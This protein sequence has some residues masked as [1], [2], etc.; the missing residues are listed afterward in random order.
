MGQLKKALPIGLQS[1]SNIRKED[2]LYVDKTDLIY[3]LAQN[4]GY[5]FL[6]RPRRF[7]KSMLCS[8][9]EALFSGKNDLFNN[10]F[11]ENHWDWSVTHPVIRL[12]M[13]ATNYSNLQAVKNKLQ[14]VLKENAQL[15]QIQLEEGPDQASVF[16]SLIFQL[17]EK[18]QKQV[19]IIV[20]EYDKAIQDT[21][22]RE[23]QLAS[24]AMDELR[25]FYSAIKASDDYI[26]FCFMTGITKFTG[27]GL[28]SGANNF[29]DIS[30]D[31]A[32]SSI[33]G[34]TQGELEQGFGDYFE[35]YD[36]E[37]VKLWYNGYNYLGDSVY[38]PFDILLFLKKEGSFQNYWWQT[39][40]PSFLARLF[41]KGEYHPQQLGHLELPAEELH[42]FSLKNLNLVSLLW[43]TGYL[44]IVETIEEPFGG[45]SFV[46]ST[47]NREVQRSLNALFLTSL[48][49]LQQNAQHQQQNALRA[50]FNHDMVAFE[51]SIRSMFAA[52]PYNNFV[53]NNLQKFEG[54]Y[55]SV[56][57]CYLLGLGLKTYTEQPTSQG[58]IDMVMETPTH[59]Y[60]VEFKVTPSKPRENEQGEAIQQII[61]Q[62]Y[63]QPYLNDGRSVV[64]LGMH[65]SEQDRNLNH[66]EVLDWNS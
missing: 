30:L 34:F 55:A 17:F 58:R 66:F 36:M 46:L 52:I 6:S 20:D 64:L 57:Y 13:S 61:D 10:L 26:R 22:N 31:P 11:I 43:Q 7:G 38:N 53:Q 39:G 21:L 65:F 23:G 29:E 40:T 32:Y 60:I 48:T 63:Y 42:H 33:C 51:H 15:H 4:R 56:M 12:D 35:P 24:Q 19:V 27:M 16:K 28:F 9:M 59:I 37:L 62:Q 18:Y 14:F 2:Y 47:P 49:H 41:E 44:T 8:T 50:I 1:F 5:Y 54:Y 3:K 25:G 45:Q